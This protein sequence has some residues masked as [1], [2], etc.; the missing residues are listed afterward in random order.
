MLKQS[1]E[2]LESPGSVGMVE[3][4]SRIIRNRVLRFLA[5]LALIAPA[6]NDEKVTDIQDDLRRLSEL[7]MNEKSPGYCNG[8]K[9][10]SRIKFAIEDGRIV[11]D[12]KKGNFVYKDSGETVAGIGSEEEKKKEA[13]KDRE[14]K[15][16]KIKDSGHDGL[17]DGGY[18]PWENSG[19]DQPKS[20]PLPPGVKPGVKPSAPPSSE[21]KSF[22]P[23]KPN[24]FNALDDAF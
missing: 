14:G 5:V 11:Y 20:Q 13:E 9:P 1:T 15:L 19:E 17:R 16:K 12:S 23:N 22:N 4:M 2:K 18:N 3:G 8:D 7:C 24:Q 6:C 10:K 21:K